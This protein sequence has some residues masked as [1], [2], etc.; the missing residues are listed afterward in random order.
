LQ[1][2]GVDERNR[3]GC[4]SP[5][6]QI[7]YWESTPKEICR[8]PRQPSLGL[9]HSQMAMDFDLS[10]EQRA[11]QESVGAYLS[12]ACAGRPLVASLDDPAIGLAVWRGLVTMGVP[13]LMTPTK[14]GGSGM[15]LLDLAVVAEVLGRH[16]A[17]G[18]FAEHLVATAC[19]GWCGD[20][21]LKNR[22]LADLASCRLRATVSFADAGEQWM[23]ADW[24][25][26]AAGALTGRRRF[27]PWA[28]GADLMVV[29]LESG[30]LGVVDLSASGVAVEAQPTFDATRRLYE[31][32]LDGAP[33]QLIDS[34]GLGER[35]IDMWLVLLAAD[36][37]G[38]A[39]HCLE[40]TTAYVKE[41]VQF[42]VPI[43]GFQA[44]KH[45]LADLALQTEPLAGLYWYAAHAFDH[46]PGRA[47]LAASLAKAHAADVYVSA[48]RRAIELHGGI[49]YT[50]E[51]GSHIWLRRALF[52]RQ[53]LGS[54]LRHRAR[55]ALLSGW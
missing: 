44:V 40:A 55:V 31:V 29:G 43:G 14:F 48:T 15:Q 28:D 51:Q 6:Q 35:L 2:R 1:T 46:E 53:F 9:E 7:V 5:I 38:G 23:P 24:T 16:A 27:V 45:Q 36:A 8:I 12:D 17:P 25:L 39:T 33:F 37:C 22:W 21:A 52:D 19:I 3:K 49:G 10:E 34:P 30:R 42:E 4:P 13:G 41:R 47:S 20:D 11:F 26:P 50:W 18:P 54:P 32:T